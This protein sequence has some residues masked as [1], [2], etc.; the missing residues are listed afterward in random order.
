[1]FYAR[2]RKLVIAHGFRGL[3]D[4]NKVEKNLLK[5]NSKRAPGKDLQTGMA[6]L[7]PTVRGSTTY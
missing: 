2:N 1:M 7:L 5:T 3:K 4:I 6:V